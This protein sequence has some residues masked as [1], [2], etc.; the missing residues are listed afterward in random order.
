M[1]RMLLLGVMLL[2]VSTLAFA[3]PVCVSD[4]LADYVLLSGGCTIGSNTFSLWSFGPTQVNHSGPGLAPVPLGSGD[5]TVTPVVVPGVGLGFTFTGSFA[6]STNVNQ[7]NA[8]TYVIQYDVTAGPWLID[9][10]LT[11]GSGTISTTGGYLTLSE[12]K[13]FD[14]IAEVDIFVS[15]PGA[16]TSATW[17]PAQSHL[18]SN[19]QLGLIAQHGGYV[20]LDSYTETFSVPEPLSLVLLG[21]GLLGLGLLRRRVK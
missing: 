5:I 8:L 9:N 13:T 1:K 21:S 12:T 2:V 10:E 14:Q 6:A 16:S 19:T 15:N 3:T 18:V 11:A 7:T 20:T 17:M 4:T